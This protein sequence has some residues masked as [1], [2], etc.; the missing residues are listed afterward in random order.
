MDDAGLVGLIILD[1]SL[2]KTEAQKLLFF[3]LCLN[4]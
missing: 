2:K 3:Y 1:F 4:Y